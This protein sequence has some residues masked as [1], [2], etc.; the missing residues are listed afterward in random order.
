MALVAWKLRKHTRLIR[1]TASKDIRR[2]HSQIAFQWTRMQR[3]LN[4]L[5]CPC[6][7]G[8]FV[9]EDATN[10]SPSIYSSF[11][12]IET[13]W[14]ADALH[15][16]TTKCTANKIVFNLLFALPK[17][18][19]KSNISLSLT[20]CRHIR[21]RDP[22]VN[23][24]LSTPRVLAAK[25]SC[26][27]FIEPCTSSLSR[28]LKCESFWRAFCDKP[29]VNKRYVHSW[30]QQQRILSCPARKYKHSDTYIHICTNICIHK[31]IFECMC[32]C[33]YLYIYIYIWMAICRFGQLKRNNQN[34]ICWKA[35]TTA[36][37]AIGYESYGLAWL[38]VNHGSYFLEP[39]SQIID[40]QSQVMGC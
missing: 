26:A 23:Y 33:A 36:P 4:Q 21:W 15:D 29:L 16:K 3:S 1:I 25:S 7:R 10:I 2:E 31:Y 17:I 24:F 35:Q 20:F 14:P 28:A 37:C 5:A 13:A 12:A 39:T 32:V 18:F 8:W 9:A 22:T 19:K 38:I 34:K 6:S 11:F 27:L 40:V 30:K